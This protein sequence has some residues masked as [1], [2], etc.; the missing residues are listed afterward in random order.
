MTK[1]E[2]RDLFNAEILPRIEAGELLET[3]ESDGSPNPRHGEPPGTR[4]QIVS[5]WEVEAGRL[6]KIAL[7]HRYLRPDGSLG[8]SGQRL[9]D[10]KLVRHEGKRFALQA[11]K[12]ASTEKG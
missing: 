3:V 4:S 6:R 8:G 5:Y 11:S 2:L 7:A 10:P 9:P 12:R 1:Q